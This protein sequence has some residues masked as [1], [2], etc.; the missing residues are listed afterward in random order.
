MAAASETALI[1]SDGEIYDIIEIVKS[2]E[3]LCL[4]I[5]GSSKTIKNKLKKQ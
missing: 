2:L 4:L 3:D 1:I 5:K